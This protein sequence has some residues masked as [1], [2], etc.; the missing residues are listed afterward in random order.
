MKCLVVTPEKTVLDMNATFVVLPLIDGEYG[1]LSGHTPLVAR[2]GAG[3][4]R[5]TGTDNQL[6]S[7]YV[8]GGF[9]EILDNTVALLSM[10]AMP[11]KDLD[12]TRAKEQL[13]NALARPSNTSEL[14]KIREEKLY[15]RR[16]RLHLAQK[17]A[18]QHQ[19]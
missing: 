18:G 16:A 8:E 19:N 3:E 17:I 14:A 10:H 11:S 6:T 9:V 7:Y 1:V 13:A 2:L 5:I 12:V 4:L 15:S